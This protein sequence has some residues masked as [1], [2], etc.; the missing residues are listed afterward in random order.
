MKNITKVIVAM[1]IMAITSIPA[2]ANSNVDKKPDRDKDK[3]EMRMMDKKHHKVYAHNAR[4]K[5]V[6]IKINKKDLR[7]KHVTDAAMSVRGVKDAKFNRKTGKLFVK[8]DANRTS[9]KAI[10]HAVK[11]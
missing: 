6:M 3:V 9:V 1:M 5:T 2:M 7:R 11:H 4:I 8:Y 10:K